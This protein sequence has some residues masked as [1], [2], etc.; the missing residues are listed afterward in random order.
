MMFKSRGVI[1]AK[2]SIMW[3]ESSSSLS[4]I[5]PNLSFSAPGYEHGQPLVVVIRLLLFLVIPSEAVDLPSVVGGRRC[6]S[7]LFNLR[8]SRVERACCAPP[9]APPSRAFWKIHRSLK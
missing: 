6:Q 5:L 2:F 9:L 7:I 3:G 8:G 1:S 4:G